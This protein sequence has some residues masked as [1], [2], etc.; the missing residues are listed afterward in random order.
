[1]ATVTNN[2]AGSGRVRGR[3]VVEE[4]VPASEVTWLV[5]PVSKYHS[6]WGVV[7]V[8]G[9]GTEPRELADPIHCCRGWQQGE[10]VPAVEWRLANSRG[11]PTAQAPQ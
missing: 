2:N 11:R 7:E 10:G 5:A 3:C 1:M 9:F 6:C 4:R 8:A